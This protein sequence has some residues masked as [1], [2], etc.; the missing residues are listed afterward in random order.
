MH[1]TLFPAWLF[2]LSSELYQV[3]WVVLH[4]QS[5]WI[6]TVKKLKPNLTV[7]T[8]FPHE[9]NVDIVFCTGAPPGS[10][11]FMW[12]NHHLRMI[13]A[14]NSPRSTVKSPWLMTK[15]PVEHNLVGGVLFLGFVKLQHVQP[16]EKHTKQY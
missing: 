7:S 11:A 14:T 13:V 8:S 6:S 2:S 15:L 1:K 5:I 16:T 10:T 4:S 3:Q 9:T 12:N